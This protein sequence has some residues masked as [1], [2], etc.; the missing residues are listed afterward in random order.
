[1]G[2]WHYYG[3]GWGIFAAASHRIVTESSVLAMPEVSI[4][5]FPDVGASFWLQQLKGQMGR[6]LALTGSRLNAADA[7]AFGAAEFALPSKTFDGLIATLQE[8]PWSGLGERDAEL[9]TG[10]L[11]ALSAAWPCPLPESVWLPLADEV[12][13]ICAGD[14]LLAICE[15]V[16]SY[17]GDAPALHLAAELQGAGSPTSIYLTWEMAQRAQWLS[18][19]EVVEMEWTVARNCLRHGDFHEGVRAKLIDRDDQ[20]QWE[21]K[22]LALVKAANI[23]SFFRSP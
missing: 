2:K 18:Y 21:P 6:L 9:A 13:A 15:R 14:D 16:Q 4:G 20:P 12:A 8:L 17:Q 23:E 5:L 11:A 1:M 22:E 7:L 19:D 3:G 10:A